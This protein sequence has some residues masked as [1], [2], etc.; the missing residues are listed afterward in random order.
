MKHQVSLKELEKDDYIFVSNSQDIASSLEYIGLDEEYKKDI[1][2][3]VYV[4]SDG[5]YLAVW[6]SESNRPYDLSSTYHPLPYYLSDNLKKFQQ[7]LAS[8]WQEEN[9]YYK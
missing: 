6:L 9:E 3:I 5:E 2:G 4:L 1:T 7:H 8:Y